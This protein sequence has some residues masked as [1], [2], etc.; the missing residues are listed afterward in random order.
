MT[1]EINN[2]EELELIELDG[3]NYEIVDTTELDGRLYIA[4]IPHDIDEE[5][6][7]NSEEVEFTILEMVDDPDDEENCILKTIDDDELY[8]RVGE[9]FIEKFGVYDDDG[10]E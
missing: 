1:S 10:E 2:D 3:K 4:L 9:A 6:L 5:E 7:E 8:D